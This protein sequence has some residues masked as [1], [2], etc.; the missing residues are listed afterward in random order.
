M[1]KENFGCFKIFLEKS[2]HKMT[3]PSPLN[4][5]FQNLTPTHKFIALFYKILTRHFTMHS[6]NHRFLQSVFMFLTQWFGIRLRIGGSWAQTPAPPDNLCSQVATPTK[7]PQPQCVF[8][9]KKCC[10]AYFKNS[11]WCD[12]VNFL[13]RRTAN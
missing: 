8:C 13:V 12:A 6:S 4:P 9:D 3:H 1:I 7:N 10:E 11:S 2:K 5:K